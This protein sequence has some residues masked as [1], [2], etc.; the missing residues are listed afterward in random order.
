MLKLK[1][2]YFGYLMQRTDSLEKILMLG[3][4]ED[5]RRR[6]WQ[7]IWWLQSITYSMDLSLSK[8]QDLVTDWETWCTAVHGVVESGTTEQLNWTELMSINENF[9][10]ILRENGWSM[11][12]TTKLFTF[13]V[14]DFENLYSIF[15]LLY[16]YILGIVLLSGLYII[17][18]SKS[19]H[20][21]SLSTGHAFGY[22][23]LYFLSLTTKSVLLFNLHGL[24]EESV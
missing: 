21:C 18:N 24:T 14:K 23:L 12:K 7:R 3:K 11:M 2:Q 17:L 20:S 13:T 9:P 19:E 8:L 4:I 6:G 5:G 16:K 1:L 15:L 10:F 22:W